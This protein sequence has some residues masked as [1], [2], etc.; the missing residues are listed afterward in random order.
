MQPKHATRQTITFVAHETGGGRKINPLNGFIKELK[1]KHI[2]VHMFCIVF[3]TMF[4]QFFS[5]Q[6]PPELLN[7]SSNKFLHKYPKT[8]P[9]IK[10][11]PTP[12]S[13]NQPRGRWRF[14]RRREG[15]RWLVKGF[16]AG[17]LLIITAHQV[18]LKTGIAY[19]PPR[20]LKPFYTGLIRCL[21]SS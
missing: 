20:W 3:A 16:S 14:F 6:T 5:S 19:W 7:K 10:K 4:A 17:Q 12:T 8:F 9:T 13:P 1:R 21:G 15:W 18:P 11:H 2:G